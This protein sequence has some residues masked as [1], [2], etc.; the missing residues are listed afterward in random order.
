MTV[1]ANIQQNYLMKRNG[2][3]I[4]K[5]LDEHIQIHGVP[6]KIRLDQAKC[7]KEKKR[8]FSASK[9]TLI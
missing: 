5:I 7:L 3:N 2:P 4:V 9:K 1:S 6:R 8:K